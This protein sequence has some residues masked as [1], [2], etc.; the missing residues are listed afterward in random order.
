MSHNTY[1]G[2]KLRGRLVME[3]ELGLF[4]NEYGD[5][6]FSK[7]QTLPIHKDV[8]VIVVKR[9]RYGRFVKQNRIS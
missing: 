2:W 7:D 5:F 3:G 6:M 9:D 8:E 4:R 1:N